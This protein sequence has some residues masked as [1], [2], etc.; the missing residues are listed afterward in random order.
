MSDNKLKVL[1]IRIVTQ[2]VIDELKDSAELPWE[3]VF[4]LFSEF[5]TL[6]LAF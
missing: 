2:L 4:R 6:R 3:K 5:R 1:G